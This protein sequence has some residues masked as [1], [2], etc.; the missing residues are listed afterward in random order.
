MVVHVAKADVSRL[1]VDAVVTPSSIQ[2]VM[3]GSAAPALRMR[4]G[5]SIEDQARALA[6]IAVGAAIVTGAGKLYCR[7]VIHVPVVEEP[8]DR[9]GIENARRATRAA[10]IA[11]NVHGFDMIGIPGIGIGSGGL[12]VEEAA[13][14][15]VDEVR[16]HRGGKPNTV[17]LVDLN[18]AM[19]RAF[20][21][22]LRQAQ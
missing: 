17:Y 19:L 1:P 5:D 8:G 18:D 15:I 3:V 2:G 4:G 11:A 20:E 13:R 14:A 7:H 22:A 9:I 21:D 16:G 10:L 6:P 12:S